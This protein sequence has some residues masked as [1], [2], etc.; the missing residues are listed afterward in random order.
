MKEKAKSKL[1]QSINNDYEDENDEKRER[2]N[3]NIKKLIIGFKSQNPDWKGKER[4][5]ERER[6]GESFKF[7][8]W[9]DDRILLISK[10][11][12]Q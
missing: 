1:I 7:D 9:F 5:S 4:E 8:D 2:E 11:Q 6:E 10:Y 3:N 12:F